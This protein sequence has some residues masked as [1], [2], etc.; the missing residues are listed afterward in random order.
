M[1]ME[2]RKRVFEFLASKPE[3]RFKARDIAN[4]ICDTYPEE[5]KEKLKKSSALNN[6]AELLNQ[7]VAE[8]G[9]NRPIWQEKHPE[10]RTSEERPRLYYWTRK[11]ERDEVREAE[12]EKGSTS[13]EQPHQKAREHD[14][15]PT[16][17]EF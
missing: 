10:L 16:L 7:L 15:Y 17:I 11:T 13:A 3:A 12:G 8:I 5:A 2:L 6:K 14:L 9:A 1:A 4:W